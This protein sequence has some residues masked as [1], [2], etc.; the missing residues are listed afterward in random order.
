MTF[1]KYSDMG[2]HFLI[3]N[4]RDWLR[5]IQCSENTVF[6]A[7]TKLRQLH[8]EDDR[9]MET[10]VLRSLVTQDMEFYEHGTETPIPQHDTSQLW[11][12]LSQELV[13]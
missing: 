4:V 2:N 6:S 12:G 11:Q 3:N 13:G 8:T 1:R 10:A 5:E 9:K 7:Y